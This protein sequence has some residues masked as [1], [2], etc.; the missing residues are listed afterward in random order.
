WWR[1]QPT[2][3][4][5]PARP[6]SCCGLC[7][8]FTLAYCAEPTGLEALHVCPLHPGAGTSC[9]NFFFLLLLAIGRDL[10]PMS[11]AGLWAG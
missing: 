11:W 3:A 5:S 1:L 9:V 10:W 8:V 7:L 6:F 4:L 2:P